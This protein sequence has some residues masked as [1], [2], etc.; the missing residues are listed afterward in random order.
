MK[1]PPDVASYVFLLAS[2][3][4]WRF[5]AKCARSLG[6]QIKGCVVG[7]AGTRISQ[8]FGRLQRLRSDYTLAA[9]WCCDAVLRTTTTLLMG[10]DV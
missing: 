7:M 4:M 8:G 3:L 9:E 6:S 5:Q 1:S 10:R 2:V